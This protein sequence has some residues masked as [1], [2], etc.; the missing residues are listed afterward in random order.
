MK[1][2]KGD[3]ISSVSSIVGS[4]SAPDAAELADTLVSRI[5]ED[6]LGFAYWQRNNPAYKK[7][8]DSP[9]GESGSLT[10]LRK[11]S[12][13]F[14]RVADALAASG[15]DLENEEETKKISREIVLF[16]LPPEASSMAP[17]KLPLGCI[18]KSNGKD[19]TKVLS[20]ALVE[21]PKA[22]IEVQEFVVAG[23]DGNVG[24]GLELINKKVSGD[25]LESSVYLLALDDL[26]IGGLDE[27]V[28]KRTALYSG[29]KL[30]AIVKKDLYEHSLKGIPAEQERGSSIKAD[31][32]NAF[33][34]RWLKDLVENEKMLRDPVEFMS[35]VKDDLFSQEVYVFSPKGDVIALTQGA[36]AIDFAYYIHSE[37]GHHCTSARINGQQVPLSYRLQ[38]GDTVEIVTSDSQTPSKDWLNL[39]TTTKAKQRIR[40]WIKNEERARSTSIGREVLS[41]D[42]RKVK[43]SLNKLTKDGSLDKVAKD[44][45]LKDSELLL[46]E[47]G[48]DKVSSRSIVGKLLPEQADIEEKLEQKETALQ[49][50]F[51]KAARAFRDKSGVK[52][53]GLND[54]VCR[55]AKCCEPL[56]G[57]ELV[58]YI[59]R[60][61]GVAVHKRGCPQTLEFDPRRL[62]EV[63]WDE[64]VSTSR[65]IRLRIMCIDKVGILAA[66]TQTIASTGMNI[67]SA[68]VGAVPNGRAVCT[69]EVAIE[70]AKKLEELTRKIEDV[71]GVISVERHR[72]PELQNLE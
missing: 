45:G 51:Q 6:A 68:Q 10:E 72:R 40:S 17:G 26:L 3:A 28:V 27:S 57:D 50:I 29:G 30:P 69:F 9:W 31:G 2:G 25:K 58:G 54:V 18:I 21:L 52:V 44:F 34:F 64:G 46:A 15:L 63:S 60:G 49:R 38:N 70:N 23:P 13:D 12:E 67:I 4:T 47:I 11:A 1:G 22:G 37:V 62:I 20:S 33:E 65:P 48:Y 59:T 56:P 7:L 5:P 14:G 71:E 32:K 55:F 43:L 42:L 35:S 16:G 61:R 19:F 24:Q 66:L 36:T 8:Q 41:K 53:S 39:V